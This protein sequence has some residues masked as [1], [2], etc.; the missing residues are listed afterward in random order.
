M[1]APSDPHA[2]GA[3]VTRLTNSSKKSSK[4][5]L[6]ILSVVLQPGELVECLAA[7]KVHDL[8]GLLVLTNQ[9]LLVLN[10]RQFEPD[11]LVVP[12]DSQLTVRGEAAGSTATITVQRDQVYAQLSRI[13]DVQLAQELAQ[14]IRGRAAA[15]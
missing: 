14:R 5:V 6:G 9:R 3:A 10:D 2:I 8:D 15:G 13:S 7:G 12:I 11:Q 1:P 4:V